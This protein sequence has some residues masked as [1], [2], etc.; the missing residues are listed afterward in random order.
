[1]S[2]VHRGHHATHA[3]APDIA[4][5]MLLRAVCAVCSRDALYM[6]LRT[7]ASCVLPRCAA[8]VLP[9]SGE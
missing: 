6:S 3:L 7:A 9:H 4:L 5:Q 2:V 8:D 1:M